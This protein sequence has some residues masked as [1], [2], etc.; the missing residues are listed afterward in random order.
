MVEDLQKE[1][2]LRLQQFNE[3]S[4]ALDA[5]KAAAMIEEQA[6]QAAEIEAFDKAQADA[7][8]TLQ[9]DH[10]EQTNAQTEAH[11]LQLVED[12]KAKEDGKNE[13]AKAQEEERKQ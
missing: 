9:L 4:D 11:K 12:E 5:A 10:Q 7:L 8:Q 6:E 3:Q 13:L 2:D 1:E